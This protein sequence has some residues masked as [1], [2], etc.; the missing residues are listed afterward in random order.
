MAVGDQRLA[1][2]DINSLVFVKI[3]AGIGAVHPGTRRTIPGADGEAGD[4]GHIPIANGGPVCRCGKQSCLEA[5][6]AGWALVRDL[7]EADLPVEPVDDVARLVRT[8]KHMALEL[9]R[10]AEHTIGRAITPIW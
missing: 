1:R 6:A 3:G 5:H 4:I 7:A 9:V 8:G 10:T 2:P